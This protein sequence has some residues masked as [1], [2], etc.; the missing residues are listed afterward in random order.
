MSFHRAP[1]AL[2]LPEEPQRE[3]G[4]YWRP[5]NAFADE[6]AEALAGKAVL[7]IFAGNGLL[8]AMLAKRGV[9]IVATSVLSS[10]DAHERGLYHPVI[11]MEASLAVKELGAERDALLMCWPNASGAA[12][13]AC[14]AWGFER[15]IAYIGEVTDY[16]LGRLGGCASDEFF[17]RFRA[18]R[19]LKSY[20]GN[21]LEKALVGRLGE[22][23]LTPRP[24]RGRTP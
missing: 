19:E 9:D 8:A 2:S 24:A 17:E 15:P 4:V 21:A 5:S 18:E 1:P 10:I 16:A 13:R 7:E 14:E 6:L 20:H 11:D 3:L 12:L 23:T 22:P